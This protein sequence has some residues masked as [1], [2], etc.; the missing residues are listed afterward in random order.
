MRGTGMKMLFENHSFTTS[1]CLEF[2]DVTPDLT[3][4]VGGSG[5]T[6]KEWTTTRE[7]GECAVS[8]GPKS[9]FSRLRRERKMSS[10]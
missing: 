4:L 9:A 3:D 2:V 10:T 8:D 1:R 5:V 7:S 6:H